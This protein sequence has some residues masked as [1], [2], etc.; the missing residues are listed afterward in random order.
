MQGGVL[1]NDSF[2]GVFVVSVVAVAAAFLT[3]LTMAPLKDPCN[4]TAVADSAFEKL[5]LR[6]LLLDISY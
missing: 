6:I 1:V 3:H 5:N 4:G 2:E